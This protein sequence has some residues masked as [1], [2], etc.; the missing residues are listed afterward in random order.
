MK[1]RMSWDW[2]EKYPV[3]VYTTFLDHKKFRVKIVLGK[4]GDQDA[5]GYG[6]DAEPWK[7]YIMNGLSSKDAVVANAMK[8]TERWLKEQGFIPADYVDP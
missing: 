4:K 7:L 8:H 3:F 1:T 2:I 6:P 5:S